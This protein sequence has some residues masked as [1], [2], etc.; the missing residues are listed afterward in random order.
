[1]EFQMGNGK[2][3][4]DAKTLLLF[5]KMG[6][7]QFMIIGILLY[8]IGAFWAIIT[9]SADPSVLQVILGIVV[10]SPGHISVS[11]SNDYFDIEADR[12]KRKTSYSGGSGVLIEHPELRP[13]AKW[14]ALTYMSWSVLTGI[15]FT[16]LFSYPLWL[17][18]FILMGNLLAW[19]YTAPPLR[20]A[21]RGFGEICNSIAIG[22]FLPGMGYI[23]ANQGF[24]MEFLYLYIPLTLLGFFFVFS[25]NLPDREGDIAAGKKNMIVMMGRKMGFL[26]IGFFAFFLTAY[27]FALYLTEWGY[28]VDGR[29]LAVMALI[30]LALASIGVVKHPSER[31]SAIKIAVP[32]VSSVFLFVLLMLAYLVFLLIF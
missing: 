13:A 19:F 1:M 9:A 6:R 16:I 12:I 2:I 10:M 30:P 28:D 11:Y 20:L 32:L 27:F 24:S 18:A 29:V 7:Y 21:Y 31:E 26:S 22:F 17:I 4:L 5:I 23:V 3:N 8:L 15:A 14:I 25:V